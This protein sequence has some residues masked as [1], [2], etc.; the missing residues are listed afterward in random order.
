ME[1]MLHRKRSNRPADRTIFQVTRL[2][3]R[4]IR[5]ELGPHAQCGSR[6]SQG[7]IDGANVFSNSSLDTGHASVSPLEATISVIVV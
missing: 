3:H 1:N 2:R 5:A 7:S 6:K 4:D